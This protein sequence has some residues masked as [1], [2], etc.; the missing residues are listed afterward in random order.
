MDSYFYAIT[1]ELS[2][3]YLDEAVVWIANGNEQYINK[4]TSI[5]SDKNKEL[6]T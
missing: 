6:C 2:Y 5:M 1:V 4:S 3:I